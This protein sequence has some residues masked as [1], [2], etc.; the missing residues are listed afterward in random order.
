VRYSYPGGVGVPRLGWPC[1]PRLL[2]LYQ[3]RSAMSQSRR[4]RCQHGQR[5]SWLEKKLC[6][7][8][9]GRAVYWSDQRRSRVAEAMSRA[10]VLGGQLTEAMERLFRP[11]ARAGFLEEAL[12]AMAQARCRRLPSRW[13]SSNHVVVR[14]W[15]GFHR[16]WSQRRGCCCS[17]Y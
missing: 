17:P 14:G 8:E 12:A 1:R 2:L 3:S 15:V 7:P 10:D 5:Q 6:R 4:Q 16:R 11:S 9:P 13:R